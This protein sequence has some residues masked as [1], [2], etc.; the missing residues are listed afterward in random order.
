[1]METLITLK[2]TWSTQMKITNINDNMYIEKNQPQMHDEDLGIKLRGLSYWY[3]NM[4]FSSL[5]RS[6]LNTNADN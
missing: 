1:M 6:F 2:P 3:M 5:I 4:W